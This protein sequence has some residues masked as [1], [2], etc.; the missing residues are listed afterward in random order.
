MPA[1]DHHANG[2]EFARVHIVP[3]GPDHEVVV[4]KGHLPG[5]IVLVDWGLPA[6]PTLFGVAQQVARILDQFE[7]L[8]TD[9]TS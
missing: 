9:A 7:P 5:E 6:I 2:E 3:V 4:V 1:K 8:T